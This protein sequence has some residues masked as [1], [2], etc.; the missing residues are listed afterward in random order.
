MGF[1]VIIG[2]MYQ[3]S[4]DK[5]T[6]MYVIQARSQVGPREGVKHINIDVCAFFDIDVGINCK[7]HQSKCMIKRIETNSHS[8]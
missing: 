3:N 8:L 1:A 5:A 7:S 2:C 4:K 6:K